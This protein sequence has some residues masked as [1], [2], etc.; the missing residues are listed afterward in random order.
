MTTNDSRILFII[1]FFIIN[2]KFAHS[3]TSLHDFFFIII[4]DSLYVQMYILWLYITFYLIFI[5]INLQCMM[6]MFVYYFYNSINDATARFPL[7]FFFKVMSIY[8]F[9]YSCIQ[10]KSF[11]I[12]L[13]F[14]LN[15]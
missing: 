10:K 1:I 13:N 3:I 4:V 9:S 2:N 8:Y 7:K 5:S 11:K 6:Y 12:L 15:V 14:C